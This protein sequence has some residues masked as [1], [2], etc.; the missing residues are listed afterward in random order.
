M[1]EVGFRFPFSRIVR[2]LFHY[3]RIALHQLAPNTWRTFFAFVILWPKVLG[4]GKNLTVK[5]FL[6]IYKLAKKPNAYIFNFRGQR[7]AKFVLLT[8]Y[9]NNKGWK[10]KYFFTQGEWEFSPLEFIK[11]PGIPL[12]MFLPSAASKKNRH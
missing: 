7:K 10:N 3:L 9:S 4:E 11:D 12:E 5:E 1:F 6:K 8:D 2:E